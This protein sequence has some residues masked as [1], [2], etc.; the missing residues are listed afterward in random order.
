MKLT[1]N[2]ALDYRQIQLVIRQVLSVKGTPLPNAQNQN[3]FERI[4]IVN[5]EEVVVRARHLTNGVI[6]V[7]D[8]WV[9]NR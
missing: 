2:T 1:G 4:A 8:A 5:G 9:K 6:S 3:V 7:T